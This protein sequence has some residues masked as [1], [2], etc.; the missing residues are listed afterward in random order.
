MLGMM[1]V[2]IFE[3]NEEDRNNLSL[4]KKIELNLDS[5]IKIKSVKFTLRN[6]ILI[7]LSNGSIAVYSHD[8]EYPE[9]KNNK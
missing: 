3:L 1:T 5:S 2:F 6:E 8:D 9:C 7:S 4:I